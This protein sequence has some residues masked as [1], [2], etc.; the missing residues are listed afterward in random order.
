MEYYDKSILLALARAIKK[1]IKVN[2]KTKKVMQQTV[3]IPQVDDNEISQTPNNVTTQKSS[4]KRS[5]EAWPNTSSS[6]QVGTINALNAARMFIIDISIKIATTPMAPKELLK[7]YLKYLGKSVSLPWTLIGY[8]IDILLPSKQRVRVNCFKKCL[9]SCVLMGTK[10]SSSNF[11]W[12]KCCVV[13][14]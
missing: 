3:L 13:G 8:F 10:Y 9:N 1:P 2:I 4:V 11:T 14:R 5:N 7:T 6:C 12:D